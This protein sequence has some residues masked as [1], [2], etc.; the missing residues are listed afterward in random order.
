MAA[1]RVL[2]K[3]PDGKWAWRLVVNGRIVAVDGSQGYENKADAREMVDRIISG[4]FKDADKR[5]VK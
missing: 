1:K 4:Q 3:R 2:Y 5:I